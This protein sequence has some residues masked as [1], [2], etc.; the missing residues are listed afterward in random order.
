VF[1]NTPIKEIA[2]DCGYSNLQYFYPVFKKNTG[3]TPR[4]FRDS[5]RKIQQRV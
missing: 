1:Q 2:A 5:Y 4:E 3:T